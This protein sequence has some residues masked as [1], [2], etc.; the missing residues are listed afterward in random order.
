MG[1][2][3]YMAP[4]QAAGRTSDVGPRSDIYSL[5][6]ILYE[7]LVGHPPFDEINPLDT[8]VQ[9]L[10]GEPTPPSQVR[11]GIPRAWSKSA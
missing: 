8:L 6:A 3:S 10:E 11:P 4:E 1:T 7:L 2:P 5:G 9:V